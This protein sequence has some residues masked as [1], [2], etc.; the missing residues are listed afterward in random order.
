MV[1]IVHYT[2]FRWIHVARLNC[3]WKYW[4]RPK[5]Y[6]HILITLYFF[7]SFLTFLIQLPASFSVPKCPS[8]PLPD[9]LRREIGCA[10]A[11]DVPFASSSVVRYVASYCSLIL[12][13]NGIY[14]LNGK[15]WALQLWSP[16]FFINLI[17]Q[18]LFSPFRIL[19]TS[20]AHGRRHRRS[21]AGSASRTFSYRPCALILNGAFRSTSDANDCTGWMGARAV[22]G[23][24]GRKM[25]SNMYH[26]GFVMFLREY[27]SLLCVI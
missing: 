21:R 12:S 26:F 3:F 1:R 5:R 11:R 6:S 2:S 22:L 16:P 27:D 24:F 10:D 15:D 9:H 19:Q 25:A 8:S 20:W 13:A 23:E 7:S 18:N 14:A 17:S 4:S